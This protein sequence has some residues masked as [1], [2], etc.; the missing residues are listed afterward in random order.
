MITLGPR[1]IPYN[2]MEPLKNREHCLGTRRGP[3]VGPLVLRRHGGAHVCGLPGR[4]VGSSALP[5]LGVSREEG[6]VGYV[7][8]IGVI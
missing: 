3:Q 7:G 8:Y 4:P 2:Y 1:Y 5:S 6:S